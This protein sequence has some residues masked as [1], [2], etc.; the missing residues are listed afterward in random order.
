[1]VEFKRLAAI[2]IP[3]LTE[4]NG[5]VYPSVRY[6][7]NRNSH[8]DRSKWLRIPI[9]KR[10]AAIDIPIWTGVNGYVYPSD[11]MDEYIEQLL[12]EMMWYKTFWMSPSMKR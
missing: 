3:I 2:E 7:G 9:R 4:V 1:M 12:A 5:Y 10:L 6:G 8:L 11:T